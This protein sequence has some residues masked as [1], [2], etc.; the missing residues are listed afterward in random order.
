M[1]PGLVARLDRDTEMAEPRLEL[2]DDRVLGLPRGVRIEIEDVVVADA[3]IERPA[4][5]HV[6]HGLHQAAGHQ[7]GIGQRK[8]I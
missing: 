7:P 4:S 6:P 5:Q 2:A 3:V 8:A 1:D